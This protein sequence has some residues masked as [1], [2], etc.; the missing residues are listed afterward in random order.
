MAR[1]SSSPGSW[2]RDISFRLRSRGV[3]SATTRTSGMSRAA[4][5]LRHLRKGR[6]RTADVRGRDRLARTVVGALP[7]GGRLM[8]QAERV[9]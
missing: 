8:A 1:R 2:A 4:L 9:R 6:A 3:H 7:C 5:G